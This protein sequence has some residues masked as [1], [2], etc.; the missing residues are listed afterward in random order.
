MRKF[1][2]I[3]AVLLALALATPCF[4]KGKVVTKWNCIG[5]RGIAYLTF[6]DDGT[7]ELSS[8]LNDDVD[9]AT[10]TGDTKKNGIITLVDGTT[11][12]SVEIK[13]NQLFVGD[14]IYTKMKK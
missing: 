14:T 6:Y 11:E 5:S 4:A 3:M 12:L 2:K 10:Y 9:V 1:A 7:V 8:T 13:G